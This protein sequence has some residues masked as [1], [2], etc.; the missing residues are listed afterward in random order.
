MAE[1]ILPLFKQKTGCI[2]F[3]ALSQAALEDTN[4]YL[5]NNNFAELPDEYINFL[6]I[7]DGF[8]YNGIELFGCSPK[9]R[10]GKK[11]I[12]PDLMESNRPFAKYDFFKGKVIVGKL[13]ESLVIFDKKNQ[14]Y[15]VADRINLRSRLEVYGISDLFKY[16]KNLCDFD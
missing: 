14:S 11:Y 7:S 1:H 9:P 5:L 15:A 12:F 13:S 8:S 2:T 16:F 3:E 6:K 4:S 10:E